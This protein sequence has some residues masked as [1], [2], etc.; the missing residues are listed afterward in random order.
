MPLKIFF[1]FLDLIVE[2]NGYASYT[3][4][5]AS[6]NINYFTVEFKTKDPSGLL[7][8]AKGG[9][10]FVTLELVKGKLR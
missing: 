9:S 1:S 3:Q 10:D 7:L 6:S 2:S 5:K 8:H 4:K